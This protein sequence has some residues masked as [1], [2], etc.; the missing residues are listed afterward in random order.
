MRSLLII[1]I[2]L[3]SISLKA[4]PISKSECESPNELKSFFISYG[5]NDS[6]INLLSGSRLIFFS[7]GNHG[8]IWSI[9]SDRDSDYLIISGSTRD[10]GIS[11][12]TMNHDNPLICWGFDSLVTKAQQITPMDTGS[13]WPFYEQ[14]KLYSANGQELFSSNTGTT[15]TGKDNPEFLKNFNRLKYLMHWIAMPKDL[16]KRMPPPSGWKEE[17]N[18]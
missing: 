12:K 15:F 3:F 17:I 18:N 8:H 6:I 5:I 1:F 7:V 16:Q 2:A 11:M 9:I 4:I 13:Y 10:D 14:I